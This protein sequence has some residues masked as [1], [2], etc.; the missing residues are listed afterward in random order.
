LLCAGRVLAFLP[1][2]RL[3]TKYEALRAEWDLMDSCGLIQRR[4]VSVR[5]PAT[6]PARASK[7]RRVC[8]GG[9][10]EAESGGIFG[11]GYAVVVRLCVDAHF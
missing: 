6:V 5:R 1:A 2:E 4:G 3:A 9:Y 11:H 7:M 10:I 8:C